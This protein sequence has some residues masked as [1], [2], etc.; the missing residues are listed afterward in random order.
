MLGSH[1]QQPALILHGLVALGGGQWSV[2]SGQ[3]SSLIG[4]LALQ[5]H[6]PMFHYRPGE[7]DKCAQSPLA[8]GVKQLYGTPGSSTLRNPRSEVPAPPAT[9]NR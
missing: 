1:Y 2:V 3:W 5:T 6:G 4:A 7:V 9:G 8:L